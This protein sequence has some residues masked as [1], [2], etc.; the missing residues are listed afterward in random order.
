MLADNNNYLFL[1]FFF[2]ARFE[3]GADAPPPA[4]RS[5][6]FVARVGAAAMGSSGQGCLGYLPRC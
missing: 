3:A 6:L 2:G 4:A 1:R 5:A